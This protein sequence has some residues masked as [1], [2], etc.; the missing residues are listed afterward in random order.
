MPSCLNDLHAHFCCIIT[1][2]PSVPNYRRRVSFTS[3]TRHDTKA[4][5]AGVY[6]CI[7]FGPGQ[8]PPW[9]SLAHARLRP[10]SRLDNGSPPLFELWFR[11]ERFNSGRGSKHLPYLSPQL[12]YP[13]FQKMNAASLSRLRS[14][15]KKLM[16]SFGCSPFV[17]SLCEAPPVSR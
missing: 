10:V 5:P 1:T 2:A 13:V 3:A 8:M 7:R 11:A 17:A 14:R 9:R 4:V 12:H 16:I 15:H 6:V